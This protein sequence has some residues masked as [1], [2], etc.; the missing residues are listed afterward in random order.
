MAPEQAEELSAKSMMHQ[1]DNNSSRSHENQN[2]SVLRFL[3]WADIG[4]KVAL[5][6]Y[7]F[8]RCF[9]IAENWDGRNGLHETSGMN[10]SWK[11]LQ[12]EGFKW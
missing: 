8:Q 3:P 12:R 6:S 11:Y 9:L 7:D 5:E 10:V 2:V 1:I 4:L